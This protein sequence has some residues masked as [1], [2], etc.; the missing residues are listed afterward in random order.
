[1]NFPVRAGDRVDLNLS[2]SHV[3]VTVRALLDTDIAT[4]GSD[5]AF[6]NP[7][8]VILPL[9]FYQHITQ[10]P[11]VV[12]TIALRNVH[13]GAD[14]PQVAAFLQHLFHLQVGQT[15]KSFAISNQPAFTTI[16]LNIINPDL[17]YYLGTQTFTN[18][19]GSKSTQFT[20]LAP[21]LSILLVGT[22]MFLLILLLILLATERRSE[23]GISRALGFTRSHMVGLLLIEGCGYGVIAVIPG[24]L[25]GIGLVALELKILS[26]IPLQVGTK[27][28][29]TIHIALPI[30]INGQSL[31]VSL[32]LSIL[33]TFVVVLCTALWMS[34][35]TIVA[36]IRNLPDTREPQAPLGTLFKLA[37]RL[38]PTPGQ[39]TR[40]FQGCAVLWALIQGLFVRGP[41]CL[42][43]A[44]VVRWLA[45]MSGQHWLDLIGLALLIASIG[46]LLGWLVRGL[47]LLLKY[48]GRSLERRL[49]LSLIGIGWLVYSLQ[50]GGALFA[51][52]QPPDGLARQAG[53]G[54]LSI[55]ALEIVQ[56]SVFLVAGAV[57]LVM[58]NS[59][60]LIAL[61]TT[62]TSHI[63]PLAPISRTSLAYLPA[64]R[65]RTMMTVSLLGMNLFLIMLVVTINIGAVQQADVALAA[66]GFQ[67]IASGRN[68]PRDW[69]QQV[70]TNATLKSDFADIARIES[71]SRAVTTGST[72][73]TKPSSSSSTSL[74]YHWL[75]QV[76][77]QLPQD[78]T[79]L[80]DTRAVG[81]SE[82]FFR[83]TTMP[84]Q[85][86]AQ[87]YSSDQAV[88]NAV[89]PHP[90]Y[91]VWR[92]DPAIH[93]INPH[94]NGF[95]PFTVQMRDGAN[96]THTLQIIGMVAMNTAW[97]YLYL[98]ESALTTLYPSAT[99]TTSTFTFL[100]RLHAGIDGE[101]ARQDLLKQFGSRY[102][103]QL[104]SLASNATTESLTSLTAFFGCYLVL[105]LLF[106]AL[107][108][109]VIMSRAVSE[110]RQHI[111][112]LRALG[113]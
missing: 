78:L 32:C 88:W 113:F 50:P 41:L 13:Q 103:L 106:G 34:Q 4:N 98:S 64:S 43:L 84:I 73:P 72:L 89:L 55:S 108:L 24:I 102:T 92:Y 59:D 26:F 37:M 54:G 18:G 86:R 99:Q 48:T 65:F 10:Q 33:T 45:S 9:A 104:Q 66:G 36:A 79:D 2:G 101:Q 76:P 21:A 112:M 107:A 105:G 22:G 90:D 93:G 49:S 14:S 91:A 46:L 67:F 12:N 42:L 63:P 16:E 1:Q 15:G 7:E 97:P 30:V 60:M 6:A 8:Q 69:P 51:V 109:G 52:F 40:P 58:A 39:Q 81:F 110:R 25:A 80:T 11:G 3:T 71:L 100:F 82:T 17:V 94:L 111:G 28:A 23:S 74:E 31:V 75:L 83:T 68:L 61:I 85:A 47:L 44:L 53:S 38:Q 62:L 20:E 5:I 35:L 27:T 29:G 70:L 95:H 57:L 96:V 87:G 19:L 77:G 56:T